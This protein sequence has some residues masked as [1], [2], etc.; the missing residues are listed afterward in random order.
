MNPEWL[1]KR[2]A[3]LKTLHADPE[4]QAKRLETLKKLHVEL[5][6]RPR[7]VGAGTPSIPIEVYDLETKT[8]TLYS[9]MREVALALNVPY[10]SITSYCSRSSRRKQS[11]YKGRYQIQKLRNSI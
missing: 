1:A 3:A 8:K 6:G 7:P 11:P 5:K 9:S 10:S 2:L 4:F